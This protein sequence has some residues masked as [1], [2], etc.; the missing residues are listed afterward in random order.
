LSGSAKSSLPRIAA[1]RRSPQEPAQRALALEQRP[2]SQILAVELEEIE[3][4]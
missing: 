4:P 1:G 3:G 2:W